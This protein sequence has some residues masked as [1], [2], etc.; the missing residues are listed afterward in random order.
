MNKKFAVIASVFAP[1]SHSRR[2]RAT[3]I[4]KNIAL[5]FPN[6]FN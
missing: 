2:P 3:F 4:Y 1:C 5:D 6:G